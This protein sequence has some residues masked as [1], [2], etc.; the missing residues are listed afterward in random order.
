M[1]QFIQGEDDETQ[2][3]F[4]GEGDLRV[5]TNQELINQWKTTD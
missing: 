2:E 1:R 5:V 4:A 3:V